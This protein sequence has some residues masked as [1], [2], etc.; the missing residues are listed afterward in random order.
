MD[1]LLFMRNKKP[2][3]GLQETKLNIVGAVYI[4][5]SAK[6][7]SDAKIGPNVTIAAGV[8][9]AAGARLLNCII[10]EDVS[11]K[12]H[13]FISHSIIGWGSVVGA[14]TRVQGTPDNPTIFGAGVVTEAEIIVRNCTVLPHKTLNESCRQQIIL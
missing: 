13:A 3:V 12:E 9:I 1:G 2:A 14:W 5:P 6:V 8:E 4:H 11:V 7:E 10:L